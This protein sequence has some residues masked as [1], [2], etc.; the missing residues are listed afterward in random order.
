MRILFCL[1]LFVGLQAQQSDETKI[2]T[3]VYF[4]N[5][6]RLVGTIDSINSD[7][8]Y[9]LRSSNS[10]V[11]TLNPNSFKKIKQKAISPKSGKKV[12]E[13]REKGFYQ[14]TELGLNFGKNKDQDIYTGFVASLTAGYHFNRYLGCGLGA[15][16]FSFDGLS[17]ENFI[18]VYVQLQSQFFG[19]YSSYFVSANIG[20]SFFQKQKTEEF[21]S[22]KG[23]YFI[24][25]QIGI[26]WT[27][28][29]HFN[30]TTQFGYIFQKAN[31]TFES[32]DS[33]IKTIVQ[34]IYKRLTFGIGILI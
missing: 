25:P 1:L 5:G 23:S 32:R 17:Y 2:L 7:N 19:A 4:R 26:R 18:P 6:S 29:K 24:R 22:G 12:C 16:Y 20:Y 28:K 10:V 30:L 27:G 9:F 31:Y 8:I 11:F 14:W 15:G 13:L 34:H 21:I 33:E 3:T